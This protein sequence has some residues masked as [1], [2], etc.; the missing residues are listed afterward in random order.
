MS[1]IVPCRLDSR[2]LIDSHPTLH[3]AGQWGV[4]FSILDT[5]HATECSFVGYPDEVRT[6]STEAEAYEAGIAEAESRIIS[7][8]A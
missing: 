4:H 8:R 3:D 7:M 5:E 1:R 6:Y 2:Y